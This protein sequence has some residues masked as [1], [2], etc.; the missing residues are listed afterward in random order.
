MERH[1]I[2]ALA[3]LPLDHVEKKLDLH[4]HDRAL[5]AELVNRHG[6]EYHAASRQDL[7]ADF[8][9]VGT[10]RK[11]HHR[12]GAVADR[13]VEF[14]NF[15]FD[16]L[17]KVRSADIGVDLGA[18]AFADADSPEIV[19]KV[20]RD[21][22]FAGRD[23]RANFFGG[24]TFVLGNFSHLPGDYIFA[25]RFNLGH[26]VTSAAVKRTALDLKV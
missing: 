25:G 21:H 24:E 4:L 5:G 3:R 9:E 22:D 1:V 20:V 13:G 17:M 18:Q 26:H 15:F 10:G 2:D 19:M 6:A 14:L 16:E 7:R 12:V 8:V 23:Q 11:I